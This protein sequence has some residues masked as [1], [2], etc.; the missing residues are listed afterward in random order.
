MCAGNTLVIHSVP[1]M[2]TT[3]L[4]VVTSVMEIYIMSMKFGLMTTEIS[5]VPKIVPKIIME[6]RR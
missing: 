5:S 1:T 4:G 6:L 3:M 2:N